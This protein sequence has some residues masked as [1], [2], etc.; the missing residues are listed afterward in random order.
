MVQ[1]ERPVVRWV[2]CAE[3]SKEGHGKHGW[4]R[5]GCVDGGR[6]KSKSAWKRIP[7]GL[8]L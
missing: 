7:T 1:D 5:G 2:N 4:N 8:D 3:Y 6:V